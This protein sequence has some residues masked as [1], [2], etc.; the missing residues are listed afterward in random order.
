M[1]VE[2]RHDLDEIAG[3]VAVVELVHQNLIPG[4]AVGAGRAGSA[5]GG[6]FG[7]LILDLVK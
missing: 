5:A 4:V 7:W 3:A 2:S 1:L 6:G